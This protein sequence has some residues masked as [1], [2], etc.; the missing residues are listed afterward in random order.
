MNAESLRGRQL[1]GPG[2]QPDFA[3]GAIRAPEGRSIIALPA[4]AVDRKI[5]RIVQQIGS[6]ETVTMPLYLTDC[7]VTEYGVAELR[8]RTLNER[9]V[10]LRAI[11]APAFRAGLPDLKTSVKPM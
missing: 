5:S 2:G 3:E 10:A 8:G 9:A 6:G 1:S 7:V 4:A 11:A